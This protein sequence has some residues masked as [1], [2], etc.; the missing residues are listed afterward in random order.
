MRQGGVDELRPAS[1]LSRTVGLASAAFIVVGYVVGASIFILPASLA[2]DLGPAVFLAYALAAL[3]ALVTGFAMAQIGSALPV[4]GANYV[5][6]RDTLSPFAGFAYIWIAISMAAAVIPLIAVG[7]A[8]YVGYFVPGLNQQLLACLLIVIFVAINS[9]GINSAAVVQ[10]LLVIVFIS[11]LITFAVGG[12]AVG[13][14]QLL[15]PL[16]PNGASPLAVA[17]TTAFFSYVGVYVI[18][19]IAGEVKE[20]GKNIPRAIALSFAVIILIYTIVPLA[21]AMTIPWRQLGQTEMVVVTA[22]QQFMPPPVVAFIAVAALLAAA[23]SVNGILLGLSRD[24]FQGAKAGLFPNVFKYVHPTTKA[25]IGAIFL[26]GAL[27]LIGVL[28]GGTI[29]EYAQLALIGLMVIQV[30]TGVALLRLR[31]SLPGAYRGSRFKLGDRGLPIVGILLILYSAG[32]FV[33]LSASQPD[34]LLLGLVYMGAGVLYSLAWSRIR[35]VPE[36][37]M[38]NSE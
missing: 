10:N 27:A 37:P 33:L 26:V 9:F 4:S 29:V 34:L 19:E 5:L 3:P 20:P 23:T 6:I 38:K 28:T 21:L 24:F 12:I 14:V 30:M 18:V 2:A 13:D 8:D 35:S 1:E 11:A 22:S 7:F 17:A 16:L 31:K 32:F 36:K 25:P 15:H